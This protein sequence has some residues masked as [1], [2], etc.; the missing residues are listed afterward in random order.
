MYTGPK[1]SKK[2]L[3]FGFDTGHGV[4]N[5][6]IG[7]R[8]YKGRPTTN[9]AA[10]S[11]TAFSNW[12]GLTGTSNYYTTTEGRQGIHLTTLTSGGVRF[13]DT[14]T[15]TGITG[16]TLYTISA[17]IKYNGTT[18]HVNM[19]YVRQYHNGSQITEG[20]KFSTSFMIDLGDGWYR[21]HRT[22]TTE[23]TT[24]YINLQ[25]YQYNANVNLH[26]QDLQLE[27]G[28]QTTPFAGH[29][30]ARSNTDSL[31]DKKRN[32][33]IDLSN[34]SF[35]TS[36]QPNFD[37]TNDYI[38]ITNEPMFFSNSWTYEMV[39]K[40]NN[41]NGSYRGLIW[42]EGTSSGGT[43]TQYLFALYN[44]SYFHYRIQ[45]ST[46]GWGNTDVTINFTPA[47]YNHI[48]WQFKNGTTNVY[49]NGDLLST[50]TSR[51]YYS[52]LTT[53]PLYIGTRNDLNYEHDGEIPVFNFYSSFLTAPEIKENYKAYKNR[54]NI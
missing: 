41:N 51:G 37:G 28:D 3:A 34:V 15:I 43:G 53:Q 14:P 13:Y 16:S 29:L 2:D 9:L 5:T 35:N 45:N 24:S 38:K 44:Y 25:G 21:A 31:I 30:G 26:I 18:P 47:D 12:S 17:K 48:V 10:A 33:S 46:T 19:F 23:S 20:G 40:F 11:T 49:V 4:N 36:G 22:F 42:A 39:V 52:G 7:S 32:T 6:A 54:F 8:N 1:I 50:D 27:L